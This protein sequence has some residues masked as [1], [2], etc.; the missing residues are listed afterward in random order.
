MNAEKITDLIQRMFPALS[1]DKVEELNNV[2]K[3]LGVLEEKDFLYL[4]EEDL[5]PHV[6]VVQ[7]RRAVAVWKGT[8]KT[9]TTYE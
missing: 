3:L 9:S 2:V 4:R 8:I 6:S 5:L 1:N 7:A